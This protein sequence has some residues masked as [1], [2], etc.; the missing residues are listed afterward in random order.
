[1]IMGVEM[2]ITDSTF[3][4]GYSSMGGAIFMSGSSSLNIMKTQF[5]NNYAS[6]S[7]G[8]MYFRGFNQVKITEESKFKANQAKVSGGDI[9][10][11]ESERNLTLQDVTIENL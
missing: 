3:M 1:M 5:S 7:G 8:A 9:F 11:I 2:N 6:D 10:A 4:D